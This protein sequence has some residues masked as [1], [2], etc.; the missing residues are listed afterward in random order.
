LQ[1]QN[2]SDLIAQVFKNPSLFMACGFG[3]GLIRPG[4]GT[5]GT[6]IALPIHY[7]LNSLLALEA[8]LFF[9]ALMFFLGIAVCRSAEKILGKSDHSSIVIDE[10]VAYGLLLALIPSNFYLHTAA[11]VL[12]RI[13]DIF[14]P[15]GIRYLD[16][17]VK[18]GLGV[19]LDDLFAAGYA[20]CI[21]MILLAFV[22]FPV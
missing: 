12:F 4:P 8:L 21:L 6:L 19:M 13:F 18:G 2:N 14:K 3:V 5:W 22:N 17:K 9:W 1:K 7:A 10:F 11:F 20:F 16:H 15:F